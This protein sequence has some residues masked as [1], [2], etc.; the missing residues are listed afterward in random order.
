MMQLLFTRRYFLKLKNTVK[1]LELANT[2]VSQIVHVD[3]I[4][5]LKSVTLI[6]IQIKP[7]YFN[8]NIVQPVNSLLKSAK[9]FC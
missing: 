3:M 1:F 7:L 4:T 9:T 5:N 2:P 8:I 6:K